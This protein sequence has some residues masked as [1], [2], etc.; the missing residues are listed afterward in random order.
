VKSIEVFQVNF[1]GL[2]LNSSILKYPG[3]VTLLSGKS[4]GEKGYPLKNNGDDPMRMIPTVIIFI[5]GNIHY[6]LLL[7]LFSSNEWTMMNVPGYSSSLC[8][9][10][11]HNIKCHNSATSPQWLHPVALP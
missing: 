11:L 7:S 6:I 5:K 2:G 3:N 10:L 8:A 9:S 4:S 1:M